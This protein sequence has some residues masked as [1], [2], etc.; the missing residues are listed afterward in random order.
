M[1]Y[2]EILQVA[3]TEDKYVTPKQRKPSLLPTA[4]FYTSF[5]ARVLKTCTRMAIGGYDPHMI[6]RASWRM[7]ETCER[8]GG[9]VI[10]EG[11]DNLRKLSSPPVV[12]ANHMST[13][14]TIILQGV[15]GPEPPVTYVLKGSLVKYP[16]F[17]WLLRKMNCVVVTRK[18]PK[19]D[20]KAAMD[21]GKAAI[22][23]GMGIVIF[24]QSTRSLEFNPAK[25]NSLGLRVARGADA[26]VLPIC[27]K[28]DFLSNG[29]KLKDF[30][31][32]DVSKPI[33]F[34]M[35]E[36]FKVSNLK[37][38]QQRIIDFISSTLDEWNEEQ[39]AES[40]EPSAA[41]RAAVEA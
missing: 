33:R 18:S 23:S 10:I 15:V 12:I 20:L 24:P 39:P 9:K 14:E 36:P 29:K 30:G 34:R 4:W 31:T 41:P 38:D 32:I 37:E 22:E 2:K 27:L 25:F 8:I 6:A 3:A 5:F 16:V 35:G 11:Y 21:G 13:L 17:G 26:D 1:K 19:A 40:D 28:T 7:V